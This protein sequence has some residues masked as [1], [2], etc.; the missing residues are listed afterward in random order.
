MVTDAPKINWQYLYRSIPV[1]E[2][3]GFKYIEVPWIVPATTTKITFPQGN[4]EFKTPVGDLV[5]SAEQSFLYL[6]SQGKLPRGRYCSITPCFRSEDHIDNLRRNWFM[7]LELIDTLNVSVSNLVEITEI[8]C[9]WMRSLL[10][11]HPTIVQTDTEMFDIEYHGIEIGS[12]GIRNYPN[13]APW[14]YA[15]GLAEPRFSQAKG[16]KA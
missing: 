13:F 4:T 5:G 1:Y 9:S 2:S 15:T 16:L 12:Y 6:I 14:I 8:C 10:G 3:N 11:D 7:K